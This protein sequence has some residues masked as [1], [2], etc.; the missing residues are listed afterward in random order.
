MNSIN[1]I[2]IDVASSKVILDKMDCNVVYELSKLLYC[3]ESSEEGIDISININIPLEENQK[4]GA[5]DTDGDLDIY[6]NQLSINMGDS[7]SKYSKEST[8]E[9]SFENEYDGRA[10][11]NYHDIQDLFE[12][13]SRFPY[14]DELMQE[15]IN[16][17]VQ[18]QEDNV[19][20]YKKELFKD[21][22]KEPKMNTKRRDWLKKNKIKLLNSRK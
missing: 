21:A 7:V 11:V 1:R 10:S 12:K 17:Q 13:A 18:G 19:F 14:N 5:E 20:A 15:F 16:Y 4:K 2:I 3:Q 22:L 6:E 9:Q 8:N